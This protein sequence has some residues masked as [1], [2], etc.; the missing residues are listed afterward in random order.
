VRRTRAQPVVGWVHRADRTCPATFAGPL[1][2]AQ[3]APHVVEEL[4]HRIVRCR[5]CGPPRVYRAELVQVLPFV[6]YRRPPPSIC[7]RF[8]DPRS[9]V[10]E[11]LEQLGPERIIELEGFA[12]LGGAVHQVVVRPLELNDTRL[13]D[14]RPL[15]VRGALGVRATSEV[16]AA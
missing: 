11:Q 15:R 6:W 8:G 2:H 9:D 4:L 14:T 3:R 16:A 1:V 13:H 12:R 5:T 10:A 7:P